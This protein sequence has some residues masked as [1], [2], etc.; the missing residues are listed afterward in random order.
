MSAR[1]I[2]GSK[3]LGNK[4]RLRR[5]ELGFTIEEAASKAGVGVKTWSRYEAGESI[6]RDKMQSVCKA[7]GWHTMPNKEDAE[8]NEFD[9]DEYKKN[10]VW[11]QALAD[12]FGNAAAVSFV[13]GSDILLDSIEQDLSALSGKPKGTHIGELE[14]SWLEG[15]LPLQ[16]AMQYDYDFLFY[17]RSVVMDYR[18]K[19]INGHR[20]IA[21]TVADELVLYLIM[22]E[23]RALMESIILYIPVNERDSEDDLEC[24]Y[25]N[26]QEWPFDLFDDMDIV[27]CLYSDWYLEEDHPYHFVHWREEQFFNGL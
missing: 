23:S 1:I 4:I 24:L 5:N 27:T 2:K 9:F 11:P 10:D 14:L 12:D 16:F 22:E 18:R 7:L 21:H 25:D 19:A 15:S 17:L 8:Q 3:E 26:W 20:F 13:I 6:R